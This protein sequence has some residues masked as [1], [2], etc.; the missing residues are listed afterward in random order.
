MRA[1]RLYTPNQILAP[2]SELELD[3]R[4]RHYAI[5]VLR[6][7][8]HSDL[9]IFNG[10]GFDYVCEILVCNKSTLQVRV[11]KQQ[12]LNN[13]SSL[14]THLY[15]GIS[16]SSHMDF[17]IQKTVETGVTSIQP[18][19]TQRTVSKSTSKSLTNKHQH[20]KRIIQSACEQCGRAIIPKLGESIELHDI[21]PLLENEYG[22]VFDSNSS[23]NIQS[24]NLCAPG[25]IKLLI[26]PEGGLSDKEIQQALQK[27]FQAVHCGPRVLRTETAAVTAVLLAQREWGDLAG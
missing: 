21:E 27:G 6:L 15:L 18:I 11:S 14:K 22:L 10:D 2:D 5:N 25:A 24:L 1:I 16:K 3:E 19:S 23:Q 8:K 13:E 17:A 7:N 4:T 20:W 26:G 12:T 9:I